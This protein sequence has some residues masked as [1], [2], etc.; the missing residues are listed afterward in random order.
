MLARIL[1]ER[2]RKWEADQLAKYNEAS[3]IPPKNWQAKYLEPTSPDTNELP[4]LPGEWCW[5]GFGQV[6][7]FQNGHAFPSKEYGGKGITLLRPGNL[8]DDGS[9]Q[10]TE[11]NTL[12]EVVTDRTAQRC[13][14][15]PEDEAALREFIE[16][17]EPEVKA[18][19][20]ALPTDV[21]LEVLDD[22]DPYQ[23][24]LGRHV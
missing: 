17:A 1:V 18:W 2:H 6:A 20:L 24:I 3:K 4:E 10:W 23:K 5:A 16:N 7:L 14:L 15:D 22:P 19:F 21:Q 11:K 13:E 12:N 9:V 8:F